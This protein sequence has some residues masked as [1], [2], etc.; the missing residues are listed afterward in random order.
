MFNRND[1]I[2]AL[3]RHLEPKCSLDRGSAS[4][5]SGAT[6]GEPKVSSMPRIQGRRFMSEYEIKKALTTGSQHLT[7]PKD[8]IV[9][10]LAQDWL[11]LQGIRIVRSP[12]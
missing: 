9:S 7:I 5:A 2:D 11:A 10:P 12:S 3:R 4:Q 1:L 8:A 6:Y